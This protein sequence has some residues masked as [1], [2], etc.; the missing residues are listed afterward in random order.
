MKRTEAE[1]KILEKFYAGILDG[2]VGKHFWTN[3]GSLVWT[4]IQNGKITRFKQGPGGRSFNGRENER[5]E[6]ALHMLQE[7]VT[8]TEILKFFQDF[9]WLMTDSDV[10]AYSAKFKKR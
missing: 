4:A 6:G 2:Q 9:G 7:W 8:D 5:F 3:G 1:R 10:T